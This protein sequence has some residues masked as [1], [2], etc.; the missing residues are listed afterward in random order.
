MRRHHG[1][2]ARPVAAMLSIAAPGHPTGSLNVADFVG[3]WS[4]GCDAV[5]MTAHW[6][7]T[8]HFDKMSDNLILVSWQTAEIMGCPAADPGGY[9]LT[10]GNK[11]RGFSDHE[12]HV[13]KKTSSLEP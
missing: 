6:P 11:K 10:R 7:I 13:R 9:P 3:T 12:V 5:E 2:I 1:L 8:G 4:G